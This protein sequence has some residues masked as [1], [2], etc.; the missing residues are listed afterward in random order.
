MTTPEYSD[1]E[2]TVRRKN[3]WDGAA[4]A[5]I[6]SNDSPYVALEIGI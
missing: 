4:K 5:D 6:R 2:T 3:T 1:A